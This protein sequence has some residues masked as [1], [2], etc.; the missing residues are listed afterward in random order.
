MNRRERLEA[1]IQGQQTDRVAFALWR[2]FP[3]DDQDAANLADATV[4]FQRQWDFDFVKV[5]P[6]SSFCLRDWGAEDEWV[7][8]IEGTREYTYHPIAQPSQWR[9]LKALDPRAGHLGNQL[10]CLQLVREELPDVPIIQTIFSPITQA[11]NL[12]QQSIVTQMRLHPQEVRQGLERIT[13]TTID[14][15]RAAKET[16]IDGIYYALQL[17]SAESMSAAEYQEF[18]RPYDLRVLEAVQDLWLNVGH[19]HGGDVYFDEVADYPVQIWNWHDRESPPSLAEGLKK[20]RGAASGGIGRLHAMLQG[21]P[22]E[23]RAQVTGAIDQ[24]GG[25][26]LVIST[27][28]VT[29]IPS[30]QANLRAAREAVDAYATV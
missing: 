29:M 12:A 26:R 14:F 30:P 16:G 9:E 27:G 21:T 19:M 11:K 18:G 5:T 10:R 24:T 8:S 22:D 15:V 6:A 23:V 7:G 25:R 4:S 1:T 20:I 28:C 2:H 3:G 13:A 17:A